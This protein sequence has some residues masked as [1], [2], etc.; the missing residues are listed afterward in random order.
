MSEDRKPAM[1][2]LHGDRPDW[3]DF[4]SYLF[5][6]VWGAGF[7]GYGIGTQ[8]WATATL[9]VLVLIAWVWLIWDKFHHLTWHVIEISI[10]QK[11]EYTVQVKEEAQ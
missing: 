10:P 6:L 8:H 1:H 11:P 3:K 2:Y 7:A 5:W 4:G 9:N